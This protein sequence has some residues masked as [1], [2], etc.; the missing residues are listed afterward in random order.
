MPG[1]LVGQLSEPKVETAMNGT[2]GALVVACGVSLLAVGAARAQAQYPMVDKLAARVVQKYQSSS[3][4][5]LAGKRGQPPSP[6]E[7]RVVQMMRD[8]PAMRTA[9][10]DRV[11]GPIANKMF[12]CRLIP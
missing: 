5:E 1:K 3:C 6:M 8:D 7:Q 4:A 11:A 12:E 9:F 2:L 10:L